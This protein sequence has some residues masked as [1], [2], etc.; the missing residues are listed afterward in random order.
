MRPSPRA[1][2][3]SPVFSELSICMMWSHV[4]VY[5]HSQHRIWTPGRYPPVDPGSKFMCKLPIESLILVIGTKPDNRLLAR[6]VDVTR[7][8]HLARSFGEIL[9]VGAN[10]INAY[11]HSGPERVTVPMRKGYQVLR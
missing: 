2:H 1:N 10:I 5:H 4:E 11:V 7:Q 9:L 8:L 3:C 6:L